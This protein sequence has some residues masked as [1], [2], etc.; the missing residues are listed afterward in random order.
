MITFIRPLLFAFVQSEA[1]KKL[2]IDLLKKIA[3]STDNTV[4]DAA[5]EIDLLK[6]IAEST[7]NTVDDAA[8]EFI[9]SRINLKK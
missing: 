6:K 5:I 1:V 2:V 9:V 7:D 4:D 3:E 8:I